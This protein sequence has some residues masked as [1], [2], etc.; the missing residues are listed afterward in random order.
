MDTISKMRSAVDPMKEL[1]DKEVRKEAWPQ[2]SHR[3]KNEGIS[4]TNVETAES[5]FNKL[6]L[7]SKVMDANGAFSTDNMENRYGDFCQ[8][9]ENI[10]SCVKQDGISVFKLIG[11]RIDLISFI[12]FIFIWLVIT[13][14]F[15]ISVNT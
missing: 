15:F 1:S 12:S 11:D 10:S 14:W 3:D 8:D 6:R 9:G 13:M 2:N 7:R 5:I 4:E